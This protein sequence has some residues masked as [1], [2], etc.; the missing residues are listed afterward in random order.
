MRAVARS[1]F[2]PWSLSEAVVSDFVRKGAHLFDEPLDARACGELA[3]EIRATR[4][5]DE[6]LFLSEAEL[7]ASEGGR[8]PHP[9]RNL[10][11]RLEPR[12]GFVE[13]APQIAEA[14]WSLLGP[15]YA[16]L[17]R[18]VVCTLPADAIPGWIRRRLLAEPAAG[19]DA[20]VKPQHRDIAYVH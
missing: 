19:L 13:R 6:S 2:A 20:C 9:A 7:A 1:D 10:L 8:D 12:L 3:A 4:R 14:F 17:D 16:I 18:K 11:Y 15:D 5:F